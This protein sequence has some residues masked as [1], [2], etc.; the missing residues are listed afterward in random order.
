MTGE[1]WVRTWE[2]GGDYIE[3]VDGIMWGTGA[4][5]RPWH[6]CGPQ[7]RG[8]LGLDYTERCNCG[9]TRFSNSP[10]MHKNETRQGRKR[11]RRDEKAPKE[12]VTCR[13][14]G[15][16]YEAVSGSAIARARQCNRCWADAL[17]AGRGA[18]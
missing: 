6:K 15:T 14:C 7:T 16:G 11:Q 8:W 13:Q 1:N 9:A 2:N 4:L 10:W 12:Q 3:S 17:V 18:S 5:P